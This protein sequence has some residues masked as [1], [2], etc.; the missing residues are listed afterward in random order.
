[1]TQSGYKKGVLGGLTGS[2]YQIHVL[3]WL[4]ERAARRKYADFRLASE[5]EAAGKFDDAVLSWRDADGEAQPNW[6][7]VQIKHRLRENLSQ[8]NLLPTAEEEKRNGSFSLY[9]YLLTFWNIERSEEFLGK[10]RYVIFTNGTIGGQVQDWFEDAAEEVN[11]ILKI[12][13]EEARLLTMKFN[14]KFCQ[15]LIDYVNHDFVELITTMRAIFIDESS[16]LKMDVFQKY[17]AAILHKILVVDKNC[18]RFAPRFIRKRELDTSEQI[19]REQLLGNNST[20]HELTALSITNEELIENLSLKVVNGCQH[21]LP[22]IM[23]QEIVKNFFSSIV[24]AVNQ[25]SDAVLEHI[26]R[27]DL[28]FWCKSPIKDQFSHNCWT[29]LWFAKLEKLIKTWLNAKEGTFLDHDELEKELRDAQRSFSSSKYDVRTDI[30]KAKMQNLSIEYNDVELPPMSQTPLAIIS[31]TEEGLLTRLKVYHAL[32][33]TEYRYFTFEDMQVPVILESLHDILDDT[34]SDSYLILEDTNQN[35]EIQT[36]LLKKIHPSNIKK[37]VLLTPSQDR[38]NRFFEGNQ[39]TQV[40]DSDV[41]ITHL[42]ES[43]RTILEQRDVIF[44]G[45]QLALKDFPVYRS[46]KSF[47]KNNFL[48]KLIR[49]E[50]IDIGIDLPITERYIPRTITSTNPDDLKFDSAIVEYGSSK[51]CQNNTYSE[52]QFLA[53]I[54]AIFEKSKVVVLASTIGMGKSTLWSRLAMLSN[55]LNPPRWVAVIKLQNCI[56]KFKGVPIIDVLTDCIKLLKHLIPFKSTFDRDLFATCLSENPQS[57][58][59]FFDGFDELPYDVAN[60]ALRLFKVLRDNVRLFINTRVHRQEM[61][62]KE[63]DVKAYYL[64]PMSQTNQKDLFRN[65]IGLSRYKGPLDGF[66]NVLTAKIQSKSLELASKFFGT[67]LIIKM[68]AE[69]Y[70]PEV[71]RYIR[72]KMTKFLSSID[73]DSLNILQ[74]FE[75]FVYG[76]FRER[77]IEKLKINE[78]NLYVQQ[79]FDPESYVFKG[80]EKLH[81]F[82]GFISLVESDKLRIFGEQGQFLE[83]HQQASILDSPIVTKYVEQ[84]P[85]FI[86]ASI[87]ELYAAKWLLR[88]LLRMSLEQIT[89]SFAKNRPSR[90]TP[91][92]REAQDIRDLYQQILRDQPSVRKFFLLL[93]QQ[94]ASCIEKVEQMFCFMRPFPL[95]WACEENI[96]II[97]KRLIE[98]DPSVITEAMEQKRSPLHYVAIQDAHQICTLLLDHGADLNAMNVFQQGALHVACINGCWNVAT[99]LI[100]HGA[101]IDCPDQNLYTPLHFASQAGHTKIVQLL[102]DNDCNIQLQTKKKWNALHLAAFNNQPEI[103]SLLSNRNIQLKVGAAKNWLTFFG[104]LVAKGF[105]EV[106]NILVAYE[107]RS[108]EN[109]NDTLDWA[110]RNDHVS[111]IRALNNSG[112]K[113]DSKGENYRIALRQRNHSTAVELLRLR[114]STDIYDHP[115]HAAA[116]AG[117]IE[118]LKLLLTEVDAEVNAVNKSKLTPVD[119][120]LK[121]CH[122]DAIQ[123]LLDHHATLKNNSLHMAVKSIDC[124]KVLLHHGVPVDT[125]NDTNNTALHVA[126]LQKNFLSA[127]LLLKNGASPQA[128]GNDGRTALHIAASQNFFHLIPTLL[129]HPAFTQKEIVEQYVNDQDK[130]GQ[131]P[132]HLACAKDGIEVAEDLFKSG[133]QLNILNNRKQAPIHMAAIEGAWNTSIWLIR[134]KANYDIVD[135][136]GMNHL[137]LAAAGGHL[138]YVENFLSYLPPT[139]GEVDV[140]NAIEIAKQKG[141]FQLVDK[142]KAYKR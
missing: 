114:S 91:N 66:L 107:V 87:G 21:T 64:T 104:H 61:L 8:S 52:E 99:L 24:F 58:F 124:L 43:S 7:F 116:E 123:L 30:F 78:D 51:S 106:T 34:V 98:E 136:Q 111:I 137:E 60:R 28:A 17:R 71:K 19:L 117:S 55:K 49:S 10:K 135:G 79:M 57:V 141:H 29:T 103:V 138:Q 139:V 80:F 82:L 94:D 92:K 72:K 38:A 26:I 59:L 31:N 4:Y 63:L 102:L 54:P 9:K 129:S 100:N 77:C 56:D 65:L 113:V 6:L 109:V 85:F 126:V 13:T 105:V 15:Q 125:L 74:L 131:T 128:K 62:E 127:R 118:C 140:T 122:P 132:M 47:L 16:D 53:D 37:M 83:L 40:N 11:E 12:P 69:I 32:K 68:L 134:Q 73:L 27:N 33:N 45:N 5:M 76:T 1:M 3:M 130:R 119:L 115:L 90:N 22:P 2:D 39:F 67:P 93:V 97:A 50:T 89:E 110:V 48:E 96:Q 108:S 81:S 18:V 14:E 112:V 20:L 95:L 75:K 41:N 86:H 35:S 142:L 133:A 36:E 25:P 88:N 120:A 44:Q 70:K 23:D 84:K 42:T 121:F 101:K 46:C